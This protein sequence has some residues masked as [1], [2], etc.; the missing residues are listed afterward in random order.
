MSLVDFEKLM[1][2]C[3]VADQE[4]RDE[5]K[6]GAA[7]LEALGW[8][9][10][11]IDFKMCRRA[12]AGLVSRYESHSDYLEYKRRWWSEDTAAPLKNA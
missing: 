11:Y 8:P 6:R 4:E 7:T 10:N 2:V 3:S 1:D 5:L 12:A 9:E